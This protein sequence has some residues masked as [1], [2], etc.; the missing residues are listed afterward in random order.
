MFFGAGGIL[1]GLER[2]PGTFVFNRVSVSDTESTS[3]KVLSSRDH[4]VLERMN[5]SSDAIVAGVLETSTSATITGS[6][7]SLSYSP[8]DASEISNLVEIRLVSH[9]TS[10]ITDGDLCFLIRAS[11]V[12][13]KDVTAIQIC[14]RRM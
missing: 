3:A 11:R 6:F 2:L 9:L 8:S 10:R 14:V 4:R 1:T 13:R 12:I 7:F 5:S